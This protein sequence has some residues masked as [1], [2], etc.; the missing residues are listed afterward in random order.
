LDWLENN[1]G[2]AQGS[3]TFG[4]KGKVSHAVMLTIQGQKRK[5]YNKI[6]SKQTEEAT[7]SHTPYRSRIQTSHTLMIKVMCIF[8]IKMVW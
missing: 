5:V 7:A 6:T 3:E 4:S 8:I 2:G 1:C